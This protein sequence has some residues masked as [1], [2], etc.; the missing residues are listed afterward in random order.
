MH[1]CYVEVEGHD[2]PCR[3]PEG[4]VGYCCNVTVHLTQG[5]VPIHY[6]GVCCT[7]GFDP[8]HCVYTVI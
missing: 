5:A 4:M 3:M 6:C 7:V 1:A 2:D 8:H